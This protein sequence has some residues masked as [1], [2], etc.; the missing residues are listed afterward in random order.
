MPS[1]A[2]AFC[3]GFST[4]L[5]AM[6]VFG[7]ARGVAD[8]F[9]SICQRFSYRSIRLHSPGKSCGSTLETVMNHRGL[10]TVPPKVE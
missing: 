10:S 4:L 6:A 2:R 5:S 7:S 1:F 3:E 9:P 8:G